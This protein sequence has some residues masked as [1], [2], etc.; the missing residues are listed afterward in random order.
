MRS[1]L[2]RRRFLGSLAASLEGAAMA[3]FVFQSSPNAQASDRPGSSPAPAVWR[4]DGDNYYFQND[5]VSGRYLT[6][7]EYQGMRSLVHRPTGVEI[8]AGEKLPGLAAPY[9]VFGNGRR[10]GDVRDRPTRVD[11]TPEG[12]RIAHPADA[13]NP[14]DIV[15]CYAWNADT[16]DVRYTIT[17]HTDMRAFEFGVSSY[18]SAGFR[19]YVSRQSNV[20]GETSS[21]IVPVDV[22]RM[23]D[24]YAL[25][26]RNEDAMKT[27]FDGRWDL[28]PF[29]VRYAVPAYFAHA[30][31]YRR[32]VKSGVMAV[33][34]AD[35][36]E[37]YAICV[38]VNNPPEN[39]DPAKGYQGIYFYLF[40]RDLRRG[41]T[42]A[43]RIRWIVGRNLPD[44]E[45]LA[46]W[47][48]FAEA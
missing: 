34:M 46:R 19:A 2:N 21:E 44:Q 29:P 42:V 43:T 13:E 32:H 12:L 26:P 33:G 7:G 25:F 9:R 5:I 17:A 40:G 14:F 23:T 10:Y 3:G 4:A 15:S 16:L 35:P 22:N 8:A 24:V 41:E 39:P 45:I 11:V 31:A 6:A 38:P 1:K 18:L 48:S 28:P 20:W 37:C 47:E 36:K 30:L 27:I